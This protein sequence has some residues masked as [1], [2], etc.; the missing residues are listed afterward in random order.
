MAYLL[1]YRKLELWSSIF[2]VWQ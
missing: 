2:K 1:I